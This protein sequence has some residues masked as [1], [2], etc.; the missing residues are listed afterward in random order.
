MGPSIIFGRCECPWQRFPAYNQWVDLEI[1][2]N[3]LVNARRCPD[4]T[5]ETNNPDREQFYE[6]PLSGATM[7]LD[8]LSFSQKVTVAEVPVSNDDACAG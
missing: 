3:Q 4:Q 1:P 7:Y 5:R 6:G 8:N 2:L